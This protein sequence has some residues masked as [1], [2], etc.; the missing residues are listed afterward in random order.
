MGDRL[1]ARYDLQV[2]FAEKG[3]VTVEAL[4]EAVDGRLEMLEVLVHKAEVQV[5][6]SNVR[7]VLSC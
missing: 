6:R 1:V 4:Q 3:D 2:I 5:E 7:V